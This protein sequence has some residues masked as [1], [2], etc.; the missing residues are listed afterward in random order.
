MGLMESMRTGTDSTFMQVVL[1]VVLLSFIV[2]GG[3]NRGQKVEAVAT[4]NGEQITSL[5]VGRA[6]QQAERMA[7]A[8]SKEPMTEDARKALQE[9][10]TQDII[11]TKA[12]LQE[13]ERLGIEVSDMEI[14]ASLLEQR[15]T[16]DEAGNFSPE[17][18]ESF[19]R[20]MR[21]TRSAF[22][23][24]LRKD[25]TMRKLESLIRLGASLPDAVLKQTY[26]E[27]GTKVKLEYVKLRSA[28]FA[29]GIQPTDAEITTYLADNADSVKARYEKD[30][31][32]LYNQG[33]KV[34][35]SVIRLA[36]RDDGL[37]FPELTAKLEKLRAE[38]EGGADFAAL[39]AKWS[40]DPSAQA[41]GSLG[42]LEA[43]A[44]DPDVAAAIA[45]L[46]DGGLTKVIQG[47]KDVRLYRL[48]S[49]V[50]AKVTTLDEAQKDIAAGLIRDAQAPVKAREF[51]DSVLA[52]W[53]ESG[54]V[55]QAELDTHNLRVLTSEAVSVG[56]DANPVFHPPADL[57]KAAASAEPGS[58]LG[59][60]FA[61]DDT[62]WVA[63]LV[64]RTDADMAAFEEEKDMFRERT[65]AERRRDFVE[66]W[67]S[68]VVA[69]AKVVR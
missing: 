35:M 60:V 66:S 51:A 36:V 39:A 40:E 49:R 10:V 42:P 9:K 48:D 54:V 23:E 41:G 63:R 52:K 53:R 5:E 69:R 34:A 57:L 67:Q 37:G 27:Q 18:Y 1:G 47:A 61:A 68:A 19:L 6:F 22:E 44:L 45:D 43:K 64:E 50:A 11:R 62:L 26:I 24:E 8:K 13:A 46:K 2:W 15:F 28:V 31:E 30:F 16:H 12:L 59:Q 4:V 7:E 29:A 56:G 17:A 32:R 25:L 3:S 20:R 14:A 38:L 58:V 65:L 33:E 21:M 55:P